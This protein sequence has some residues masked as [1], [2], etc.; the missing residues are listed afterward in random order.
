MLPKRISNPFMNKLLSS[1]LIRALRCPLPQP[2]QG[3]LVSLK[4]FPFPHDFLDVFTDT[5]SIFLL[6]SI[7]Y[8]FLIDF[9]VDLYLHLDCIFT[10]TLLTMFF[11]LHIPHRYVSCFHRFFY[12]IAFYISI[13]SNLSVFYPTWLSCYVRFIM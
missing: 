6:L 4:R 7:T 1:I 9:Q 5:L 11:T 13:G 12:A 8:G 2:P 10:Y 3:L